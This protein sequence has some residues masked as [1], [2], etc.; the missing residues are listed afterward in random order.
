M[1]SELIG[2][3]I[4][5]LSAIIL[6]IVES[7]A[8]KKLL[9]KKQ[10]QYWQFFLIKAFNHPLKIIIILISVIYLI[11]F[12]YLTKDSFFTDEDFQTAKLIVFVSALMCG[13]LSFIKRLERYFLKSNSLSKHHEKELHRSTIILLMK[14]CFVTSLVIGILILLHTLGVRMQAVITVISLSGVAIGISSRDLVASFF[15]TMFIYTNGPFVIGDR[16]KINHLEGVVENIT[17]LSTRIRLDNK[18]LTYIPNIQFLNVTIENISYALEKRVTLFL[19]VSSCDFNLINNFLDKIVKDIRNIEVE[20]D[21]STHNPKMTYEILEADEMEVKFKVKI[22]FHKYI[23]NN[24][25][26]EQKVQILQKIS[27]T[28]NQANMR[29]HLKLED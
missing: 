17:W 25:L 7:Y 15:G 22:Y 11:E 13:T 23:L 6:L 16:I 26:S 14:L 9:S 29:F 1:L 4:I 20:L 3:F 21:N 2:A 24:E 27:R 10:W 19:S 5:V 12:F 18:N 28:F 8:F